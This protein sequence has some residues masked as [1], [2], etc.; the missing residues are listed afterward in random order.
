MLQDKIAKEIGFYY[1]SNAGGRLFGTLLGG[2]LYDT[3]Q[4]R[5]GTGSSPLA[6]VRVRLC[7]NPMHY[8]CVEEKGRRE[9]GVGR[10]GCW[11]E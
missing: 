3:T 7:E 1:M 9:G 8:A 4:V 11:I 6:S 10:S 5:C 2:V